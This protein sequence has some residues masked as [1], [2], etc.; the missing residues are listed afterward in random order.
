MTY[1]QFWEADCTLARDYRAAHAL[2]KSRRNQELWLE[3]LY[4]YNALCRV[5]PILHA[6]APSG[7]RP[8]PYLEEPFPLT[9][10]EVQEAKERAEIRRFE[11]MKQQMEAIM[12]G[13]NRRFEE[14]EKAD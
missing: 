12:V 2:K 8:T 4:F 9:E 1:Q 13:I 11:G 14:G 3:G 10:K 5:S 7:T 6:F